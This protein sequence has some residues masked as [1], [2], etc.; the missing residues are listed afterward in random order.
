MTT[1]IHVNRSL[2]AKNVKDGKQRPV[3]TI[4]RKG[5]ITYAKEVQILGPS[6]LVQ[7]KE[8][9]SCGA[10]AWIETDSELGLVGACS[11]SEIEK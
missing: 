9:L 10:R 4:K 3:Y 2:I 8:P 6:T 1:V 11:F 7:S 5:R